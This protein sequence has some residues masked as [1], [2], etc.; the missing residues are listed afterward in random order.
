MSFIQQ[1]MCNWNYE[2]S[3]F[4]TSAKRVKDKAYS[5]SPCSTHSKIHIRSSEKQEKTCSK[6]KIHKKQDVLLF[7]NNRIENTNTSTIRY[8]FLFLFRL[9]ITHSHASIRLHLKP[10]LY[11]RKHKQKLLSDIIFFVYEPTMW[12]RACVVRV[13]NKYITKKV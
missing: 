6:R 5:I 13:Y 4:L 7:N 10:N 1:S 3:L 11:A 12:I 2:K 9:Y 8:L